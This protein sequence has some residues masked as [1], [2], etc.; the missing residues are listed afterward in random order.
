MKRG[1][2]E[3]EQVNVLTNLPSA[4]GTREY[5]VFCNGN[6]IVASDEDSLM[7]L[8][9]LG[10]DVLSIELGTTMFSDEELKQALEKRGYHG[11]LTKIIK[12]EL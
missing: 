12:I 5:R 4:S 7:D 10:A 8:V 9:R 3:I 6:F 11:K 1:K 2:W